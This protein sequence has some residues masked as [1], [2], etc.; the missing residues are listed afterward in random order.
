MKQYL[1][2]LEPI[3]EKWFDPNKSYAFRT[4]ILDWLDTHCKN[5]YK[6]FTIDRDNI[7]YIALM[8]FNDED[9]V[10]FSMEWV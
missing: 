2:A 1:I 6:F 7:A 3:T 9:Y 4:E 8:F 5:R 10:L